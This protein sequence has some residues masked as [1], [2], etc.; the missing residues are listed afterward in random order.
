MMNVVDSSAWLEFFA[1][2]P[3]ASVF[4]EPIRDLQHLVVPTITV[5]AVHKKAT[6]QRGADYASECIAQMMGGAIIPLS[7]QLALNSSD[8]GRQYDLPLADSVVY[9]TALAVNGLTWTC[10]SDFKDL[11]NVRYFDK[12]GK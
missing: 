9:A 3:L 4:E 8:V 10:D 7:L 11:P 1:N 12:R 2:N 6:K 5:L